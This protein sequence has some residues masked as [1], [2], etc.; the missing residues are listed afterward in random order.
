MILFIDFRFANNHR[1]EINYALDGLGHLRNAAVIS[2][3]LVGLENGDIAIG[4][5]SNNDEDGFESF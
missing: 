2:S 5:G 3:I 4:G 1:K